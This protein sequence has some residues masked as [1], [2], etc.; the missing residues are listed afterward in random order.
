MMMSTKNDNDPPS[1]RLPRIFIEQPLSVGQTITIPEP[2]ARHLTQVLRLSVQ[3]PVLVFNGDGHQ[4]NAQITTLARARQAMTLQILTEATALC[5]TPPTLQLTLAVGLSRAERF[6]LVLQKAVELGISQIIPLITKRTLVQL[7]A[8]RHA[9]RLTHWQRIIIGACEQSGRCCLPTLKPCCPFQDWLE[10][11]PEEGIMLDHRATT[12]LNE[13]P[14][15]KNGRLTLLTG[16][17][18]GLTQQERD[19]AQ[20][21]GLQPI[22]LG[23]RILRTETAPLAA[24]AAIQMVWGDFKS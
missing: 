22:R 24:L 23:P 20:A 2:A 12:T 21:A 19:S 16:P 1:P 11:A 5:A 18:A 8:E 14:A 7:N 17:E 10:Q 13:R 15:P 4:Y 9:K 6:D 3:A